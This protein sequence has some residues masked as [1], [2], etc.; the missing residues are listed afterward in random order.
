MSYGPP[1][2]FFRLAVALSCIGLV[3]SIVG[4]VVAVVWLVRHVRFA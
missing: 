3:A 2:W 1:D 4:V